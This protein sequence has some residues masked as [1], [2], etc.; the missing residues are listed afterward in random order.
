[1]AGLSTPVCAHDLGATNVKPAR[2]I[3]VSMSM[4]NFFIGYFLMLL[5]D[6]FLLGFLM[7]EFGHTH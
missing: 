5:S 7:V 4:F 2:A 3:M 1:M 6:D